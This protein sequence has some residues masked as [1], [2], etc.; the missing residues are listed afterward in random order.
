M[1]FYEKKKLGWECSRPVLHLF[2]S[3]AAQVALYVKPD[4]PKYNDFKLNYRIFALEQPS[5]Q[6]NALKFPG[7]IWTFLT[8]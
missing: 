5:N 4:K 3:S 2:Y 6:E 8:P 7:R 1:I